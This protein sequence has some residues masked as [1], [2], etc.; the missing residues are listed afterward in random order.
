MKATKL[1]LAPILALGLLLSSCSKE[2]TISNTLTP[3]KQMQSASYVSCETQ[4]IP[5]GSGDYYFKTGS[6]NGAIGGNTKGITYK[7]YNTE[8]D[9]VVEVTYNRTPANS[10][11]SST[12]KVTVNGS[13]QT[14]TIA[15]HGSATYTFALAGGWA[16]CDATSWSL[17]ETVYDGAAALSTS[18]SY[19]LIG[20]CST[21][22]ELEGN[23]F[24]GT[25]NTCGT[26]REVVYTLSSENGITGF[27]M[28]GGLT[29]HTTSEPVVTVTGGS[30]IEVTKT[31]VGND[32]YI[33]KV[34]GNV[35]SCSDVKVT[36]N[37]SSSNSGSEITGDWSAEDMTVD[38]LSCP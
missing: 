6:V 31:E 10:G 24:T 28:Q 1:F 13:D 9:F 22:C 8:T 20:I 3:N 2:E 18:G 35:S 27:K 26:N 33:I 38:A 34:E 30:G 15:N 23:S 29:A 7:V 21:G 14:K 37:W 11:A 5:A 17:I 16:A 12:I 4:C 25:V 36:I 19:N 32:N